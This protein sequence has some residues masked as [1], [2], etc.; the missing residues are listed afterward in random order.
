MDLIWW[1][2]GAVVALVAF[3]KWWLSRPLVHSLSGL[4]GLE[5]F[6][7]DLLE[8]GADGTVLIITHVGTGHFVQF[9]KYFDPQGARRLHFGFPDAPWSREYFSAVRQALQAMGIALRTES[10]QREGVRRF[11]VAEDL[12]DIGVAKD[13]AIAALGAIGLNREDE[14]RAQ[15]D[16]GTDPAQDLEQVKQTWTELKKRKS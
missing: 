9:V 7:G 12:D 1:I 10:T 5:K 16:G 11:L 2:L 14:F 15:F 3:A 13:I 6:L 4:D 8:R